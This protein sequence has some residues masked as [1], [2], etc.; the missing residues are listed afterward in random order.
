MTLV[1]I[2]LAGLVFLVYLNK[3][4]WTARAR[5]PRVI[6]DGSFTIEVTG[7]S[8]YLPSFE[9]I[10]GRRT[11]DCINRKTAAH[12][13]LEND[14]RSDN[15]AVRVSIEGYTVG[16]LPQAPARNLIYAVI[17]VGLEGS[18]IFECAAHIRGSWDKGLHK[19]GNFG[20]WLDIPSGN[21]Q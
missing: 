11:A 16:Y 5:P 4:R 13:I 2:V 15:Q 9:K 21:T 12:L 10:C 8:H 20:V 3:S 17:G 7:S 18:R 6:G 1:M 19:Q 14:N